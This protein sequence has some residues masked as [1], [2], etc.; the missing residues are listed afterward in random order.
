MRLEYGCL[1]HRELSISKRG[2]QNALLRLAVWRREARRAAILTDRAAMHLDRV[3]DDQSA[4]QSSNGLAT[5][6]AIR[7]DVEGVRPA[8]DRREAGSRVPTHRGW[9]QDHVDAR[10]QRSLALE[11]LE[12]AHVAMIRDERRRTRRVVRGAWALQAELEGYTATRHRAVEA[13]RRV[14]TATSR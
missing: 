11:A 4:C 10:A 9:I 6:V 1:R 12:G 2:A 7:T 14:N 13:C 8:S 3:V 5:S